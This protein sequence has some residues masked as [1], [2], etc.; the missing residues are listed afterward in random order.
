[1]EKSTYKYENGF[2]KTGT[3]YK[4]EDSQFR[5]NRD[6]EGN[7]RGGQI[8]LDK[9]GQL[10]SIRYIDENDTCQTFLYRNGEVISKFQEKIIDGEYIKHGAYEK[11]KDGIVVAIGKYNAGNLDGEWVTLDENNKINYK[12]YS[13]GKDITGVAEN[14]FKKEMIQSF[15]E[16]VDSI[17]DDPIRAAKK[18]MRNIVTLITSKKEEIPQIK[19]NFKETP[20][21]N[22]GEIE[23]CYCSFYKDGSPRIYADRAM[24]KENG[25]LE[26]YGNLFEHYDNGK[27]K[28]RT[29]YNEQGKQE[30]ECIVYHENGQLKIQGQFMNGEAVGNFK[31]FDEEGN[32]KDEKF[33]TKYTKEAERLTYQPKWKPENEYKAP[34]YSDWKK[35]FGK[36]RIM[37][38][39]TRRIYNSFSKIKGKENKKIRKIKK[40]V[41]RD[42]FK[43]VN[44]S[45]G[46]GLSF[47]KEFER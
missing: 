32:L 9:N 15:G 39:E 12:K 24:K 37:N 46:K 45:K 44:R 38:D 25:D 26:F 3:F 36:E 31:F 43:E 20:E 22:I 27:I 13:N 30:G 41:I 7:L 18:L 4:G 28:V 21:L 16:I 17:G 47:G 34:N 5:L 8:E 35:L 6:S 10:H 1:M 42:I 2:I 29:H 40:V 23:N 14:N 19:I 33:Y 11:Y